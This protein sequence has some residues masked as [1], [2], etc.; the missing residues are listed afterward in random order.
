MRRSTQ[1]SRSTDPW[2]GNLRLELLV[3]LLDFRDADSERVRPRPD[4]RED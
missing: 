3:S 1:Y 2:F 4:S